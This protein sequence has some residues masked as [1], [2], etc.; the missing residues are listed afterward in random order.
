MGMQH[1]KTSAS[2]PILPGAE[3]VSREKEWNNALFAG[4]GFKFYSSEIMELRLGAQGVYFLKESN[5]N[6][7]HQY[8]I[9]GL[10]STRFYL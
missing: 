4:I 10:L 8:I 7:D 2:T 9:S 3:L 6:G 1:N 5:S